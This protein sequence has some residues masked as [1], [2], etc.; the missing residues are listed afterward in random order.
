M[1]QFFLYVPDVYAL[2][3]DSGVIRLQSAASIPDCCHAKRVDYFS[4][5]SAAYALNPLDTFPP[6]FPVDGEVDNLLA[7]SRCNGIWKTTRHNKHNG[8]L[9]APTGY[10]LVVYVA[11]L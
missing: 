9:P 3:C 1:C 8:L 4:F 2:R 7:T 11:D 10:R 6:N 5:I